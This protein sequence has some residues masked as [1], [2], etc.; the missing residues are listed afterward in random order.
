MLAYASRFSLTW[1]SL[2][3][4]RINLFH[5]LKKLSV[6]Y[7][8]IDNVGLLITEYLTNLLRH[9]NAEGNAV[10]FE[11]S[12]FID[13][14]TFSIE[15]VTPFNLALVAFNQPTA[16]DHVKSLKTG[17]M[18]IG[19]IHQLFPDF[20]YER[21][22]EVNHFQI[23][24]PIDN[25]IKPSVFVIDDSKAILALI[26]SY[27][28]KDYNVYC[29]ADPT[30]A[31]KDVIRKAPDFIIVD[32][33]M[34]HMMGDEFIEVVRSHEKLTHTQIIVCSGD[35]LGKHAQNAVKSG[36]D[37]MINKPLEKKQLT[38]LLMMLR[39]NALRKTS[40]SS[41]QNATDRLCVDNIGIYPRGA[42]NTSHSGD[43]LFTIQSA[44]GEFV[45]LCDVMGHGKPASVLRDKLFGLFNGFVLAGIDT[46]DA[47]MSAF[48]DAMYKESLESSALITCV[49]GIVNEY[50]FSWV[51]A[52]HPAPILMTANKVHSD[53]DQIQVV[54]GLFEGQTY[55]CHSTSLKGSNR[56][57][58]LTDGVY[59][60][61][62][63]TLVTPSNV[64]VYLRNNEKCQRILKCPKTKNADTDLINCIWSNSLTVSECDDDASIV[65]I[66]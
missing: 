21:K 40:A 37:A 11:I 48:S 32:L 63:H 24:L 16:I 59:E 45:I 49:V 27:L 28:A 50:Q 46:P 3:T 58:L 19:L 60:N 61:T 64:I 17:G 5:V 55:Q 51:C 62:D 38:Q 43:M 65:L 1:A 4:I 34:P 44:K 31:I 42:V 41:T 25:T 2:P 47:L 26:E 6:S 10:N 20:I 53:D 18:G 12:R 29:Y 13:H 14:V 36:V 39:S 52:G 66:S 22:G 57:L 33:Q 56:I 15:D 8:Q 30:K 9:A 54:P 7:E 23:N 35:T